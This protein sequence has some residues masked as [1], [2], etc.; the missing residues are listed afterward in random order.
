VR[1]APRRHT[2]FLFSFGIGVALLTAITLGQAL[3]TGYQDWLLSPLER[4]R[5][6]ELA[7]TRYRLEEAKDSESQQRGLSGRS[8]LGYRHGMLFVF[9]RDEEQCIWM[10][11]MKFSIDIVWLNRNKRI[12]QIKKAVSP[13][14]Y[15]DTYC[16]DALYVIELPAGTAAKHYLTDG[17]ALKF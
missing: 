7:Q 12:T 8:G 5:T 14:T 11:D 3:V 4:G 15:P 17:Q 1:N 16:E 9:D 13:A 6:L 10:K 2:R